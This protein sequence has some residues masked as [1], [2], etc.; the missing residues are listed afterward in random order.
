VLSEDEDGLL[1]VDAPEFAPDDEL[2]VVEVEAAFELVLEVLVLAVE[3]V[4]IE[5]VPG[6]PEVLL[7][8]IEAAP[9]DEELVEVVA[10]EMVEVVEAGLLPEIVP[11]VVV[12]ELDDAGT[13]LEEE[14]LESTV[15]VA[16]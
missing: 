14:E 6:A 9:E 7:D 1:D 12:E 13:G 2:L 11:V 5:V 8:V 16:C 3:L 10:A 15:P 4:L